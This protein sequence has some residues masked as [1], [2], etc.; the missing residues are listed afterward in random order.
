MK[1]YVTVDNQKPGCPQEDEKVRQLEE[2]GWKLETVRFPDGRDGQRAE[3]E[4]SREG[5]D[6][7]EAGATGAGASQGGEP[8][9]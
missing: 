8:P 3:I 4:L 6:S 1:I 7:P 2:K 9:S 5:A